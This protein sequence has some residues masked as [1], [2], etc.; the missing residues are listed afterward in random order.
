MRLDRGGNRRGNR[1]NREPFDVGQEIVASDILLDDWLSCNQVFLIGRL[2]LIGTL[3]FALLLH[4]IE[5]RLFK[6]RKRL[7]NQSRLGPGRS[8]FD[9]RR[10]PSIDD[11][12][13]CIAFLRLDV[14][15]NL[16]NIGNIGNIVRQQIGFAKRQFEFAFKIERRLIDVGLS[17]AGFGNLRRD[18]E[19]MNLGIVLVSD[20]G[21]RRLDAFGLEEHRLFK[22]GNGLPHRLFVY[23]DVFCYRI[24][25]RSFLFGYSLEAGLFDR[26]R[27]DCSRLRHGSRR[28]VA[29]E[30]AKQ[31]V[32]EIEGGV[33]THRLLVSLQFLQLLDGRP[34]IVTDDPGEF[35][36]RII[37]CQYIEFSR[38]ASCELFVCHALHSQLPVSLCQCIVGKW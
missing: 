22:L 29:V 20:G 23:D 24:E 9:G 28:V 32:F 21:W 8:G 16:G 1:R 35:G 7:C 17:V 14:R 30:R 2:N 27:L 18:G 4:H 34:G 15:S 19:G 37:V 38:P 13:K 26:S 6:G 3:N 10:L 5:A 12:V 25:P 33:L 31:F 36:Q 11:L